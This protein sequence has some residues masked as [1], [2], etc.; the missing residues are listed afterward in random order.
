[1]ITTRGMSPFALMLVEPYIEGSKTPPRHTNYQFYDIVVNDPWSPFHSN[2]FV[3]FTPRGWMFVP[4]TT[5]LTPP[6]AQAQRPA[7]GTGVFGGS[8]RR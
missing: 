6:P 5:L 7:G 1:M 3:P 4:D 2:P 8:D